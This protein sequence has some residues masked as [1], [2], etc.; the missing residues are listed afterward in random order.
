MKSILMIVQNFYPE[1]GSAA[2]RLKNV[3]LQLKE[4][5]YEVTVL[6]MNPSYPNQHLY[7]DGQFWNEKEIEQDVMRI[8]VGKVKGY[9][10]SVWLRLFHY[11]E[12]M[13]LFII[14]I[15]RLKKK[16]DYVFIST[17]PIF[18]SVAGM[19]AKRKMKAKLI[20]DV[21][22]LWPESLVGVGVFSNRHVLNVAYWFEKKLYLASDQ[23]IVNSPSYRDYIKAK[24]VNEQQIRFIPNSLTMEELNLAMNPPLV[25]EGTFKV[26]YTG[27]IGLAQD[28]LKLLEVAE[29]L[30]DHRHIE[31]VI[32]GYGFRKNEVEAKINAKGLHNVTLVQAKNRAVTLQEISTAHIAYVSLVER[33]VFTK[34]LPGKII[35]YMC[36][37]KPI[38]ADVAGFAAEMI[39]TA[40][41]GLVAEKRSVEEIA[42]LIVSLSKNP[43]LLETLGSNGYQYAKEHFC[44]NHNIEGLR[45]ILEAQ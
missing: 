13:L 26:I 14:T 22:D 2:N 17:P 45:H 31:F 30:Q 10:S 1:I 25:T 38:V 28:I 32:I 15:F 27:N 19:L 35:D 3:Y 44:W 33:S 29:H 41:C 6:T 9:T 4:N 23:I 5:G 12:T 40:Q 42:S 24:G 34:V 11:L 16:Y 39:K 36:V 37:G 43:V 7:E 20:T 21:R 8:P 18:P